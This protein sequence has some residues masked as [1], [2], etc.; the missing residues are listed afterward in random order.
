[1]ENEEK[2]VKP[3]VPVNNLS[4]KDVTD[5]LKDSGRTAIVW[6]LAGVLTDAARS[7]INKVT[8]KK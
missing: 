7:L 1:M 4:S 2:K 6:S 3:E 8:G 5:V